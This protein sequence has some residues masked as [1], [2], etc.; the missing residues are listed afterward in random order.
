MLLSCLLLIPITGIFLI[1]STISYESETLK[2]TYYKNIA[3]ISSILTMIVSLIIF[4]LFDFSSN[5][6]QFVQEHY[7]LNFFNLYLGIDGISIYFVLLTTIIMPIAILS[8]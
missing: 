1:F 2:I 4:I 5:Q 3:F 7:D 6:F 8:N